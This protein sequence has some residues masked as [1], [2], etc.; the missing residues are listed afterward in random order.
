M[1]K[2][3]FVFICLYF[4]VSACK[5]SFLFLH[6]KTI[7]LRFSNNST[8]SSSLIICQIIFNK[9]T[10]KNER[11]FSHLNRPCMFKAIDHKQNSTKKMLYNS[12]L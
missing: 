2:K 10:N 8:F 1:T 6:N 12:I 11:F 3:M 5:N 9:M 7:T 4:V